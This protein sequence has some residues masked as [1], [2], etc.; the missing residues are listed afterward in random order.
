[1]NTGTGPLTK[2]LESWLG[3][4]KLTLTKLPIDKPYP[5][6]QI[7]AIMGTGAPDVE[8]TILIHDGHFWLPAR[9]SDRYK[10]EVFLKNLDVF[11]VMELTETLGGPRNLLIKRLKI[12]DGLQVHRPPGQSRLLGGSILP[13][14]QSSQ[15]MEGRGRVRTKALLN[16]SCEED[17]AQLVSDPSSLY[18]DLPPPFNTIKFDHTRLKKHLLPTSYE[19]GID[20]ACAGTFVSSEY[21]MRDG[22]LRSTVQSQHNADPSHGPTQYSVTIRHT[23]MVKRRCRGRGAKRKC[24]LD[25]PFEFKCT[26]LA[27]NGFCKHIFAVLVSKFH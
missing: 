22:V 2:V 14:V 26:C 24:E 15:I 4:P 20:M 27:Y 13:L 8:T 3:F 12:P 5:R 17:R 18:S 23:P 11:H 1:V 9:I 21:E 16:T 19:R 6:V 7:K 10:R 25:S